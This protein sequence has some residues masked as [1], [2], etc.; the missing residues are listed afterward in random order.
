VRHSQVPRSAFLEGA[1]KWE[2]QNLYRRG[3]EAEDRR[4]AG[5]SL[6][7]RSRCLRAMGEKGKGVARNSV[8]C[9]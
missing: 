5:R 4:A 3:S 9:G 2:E 6:S 1:A 8:D 7:C